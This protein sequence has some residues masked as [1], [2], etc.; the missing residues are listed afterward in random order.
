MMENNFI[1]LQLLIQKIKEIN[2]GYPLGSNELYLP[3]NDHNQ[4][5]FFTEIDLN[6][7]QQL[8]RMYTQCDGMSLPDVHNGYFVN[9]LSKIFSTIKSS[10][11]IH[12]EA[13]NPVVVLPF[14][15]TGGGDLFVMNISNSKI[16]L[17]RPAMLNS[18]RYLSELGSVQEIAINLNDFIRRL[19][20]DVQAFVENKI[21]HKYMTD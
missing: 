18:N 20:I 5:F 14:G 15:S 10:S 3:S 16:L 17:L 11:F 12:I 21:S 7:Q 9:R 4:I 6:I 8:I 19:L 2:L 13:N 1:K